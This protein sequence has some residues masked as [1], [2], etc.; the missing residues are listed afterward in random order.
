[1]L[2]PSPVTPI[3][4][5]AVFLCYLCPYLCLV[6]DILFPVDVYCLC[7]AGTQVEACA[8]SLLWYLVGLTR[9][10]FTQVSDSAQMDFLSCSHSS[11]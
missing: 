4:D 5:N 3:R 7:E 1:M 10:L 8:P 9:V 6:S 2:Q 11:I